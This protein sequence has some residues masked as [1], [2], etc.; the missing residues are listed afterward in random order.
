MYMRVAL[1]FGL[2][3]GHRS[4]FSKDL[5]KLFYCSDIA[6]H[7]GHSTPTL[8]VYIAV[9]V[10]LYGQVIGTMWYFKILSSRLVMSWRKTKYISYFWFDCYY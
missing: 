6:L 3:T 9:S 2:L 1:L 7:Q 8:P 5:I 4:F 10:I